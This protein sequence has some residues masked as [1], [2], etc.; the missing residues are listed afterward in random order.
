MYYFHLEPQMKELFKLVIRVTQNFSFYH[1]F[2]ILS[3]SMGEPKTIPWTQLSPI[4]SV[5]EAWAHHNIQ[6]GHVSCWPTSL[7][8]VMGPSKFS[9]VF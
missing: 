2:G 4:R 3:F 8:W 6:V 7:G 9:Y 1:G 5:A